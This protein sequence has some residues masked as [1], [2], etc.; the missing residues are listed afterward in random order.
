[1]GR[2]TAGRARSVLLVAAPSARGDWF[3]YVTTLG[4][5]IIQYEFAPAGGALTAKVP[6][7]VPAG[8]LPTDAAVSP[9]GKSVYVLNGNSAT[10]SQYTVDA[11]GAL[12]PKTPPTVPTGDSPSGVVVSPDG[13]SVY[14]PN[15]G[16]PNAGGDSVSQY[17]VGA[18]GALAPKSTGM[19]DGGGSPRQS[20]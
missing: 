18:N 2:L 13:S 9:D 14:V 1:V 15:G 10:V 20:A 17:S 8:A 12:S 19:A 7:T 5:P 6:P 4:G 3:V 11:A 16:D